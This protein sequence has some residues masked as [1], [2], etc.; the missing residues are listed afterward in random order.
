MTEGVRV[1]SGQD[2]DRE[3]RKRREDLLRRREERRP[4]RID[5]LRRLDEMALRRANRRR[6]PSGP[7]AG[8]G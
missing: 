4:R 7:D 1:G 6:L 5:L 8:D 3:R 2:V